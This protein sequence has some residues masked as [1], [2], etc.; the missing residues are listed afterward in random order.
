MIDYPNKL[1]KIFDKL[2]LFNIKPIIVGGYIRDILIKT[3]LNQEKKSINFTFSKDIDIEV[4]GVTSLNLLEELLKEFG[5]VNSVGKSF[6]ICKLSF[7][8]LDL[9]FSLPRLDSKTSSGHKGF[10][11][12]TPPDIDFSMASFRRDFT[13]NSIGYDVQEKKIL[14]P[15]N[16]IKDLKNKTLNAI[17]RDTF[18]EDPL[19]VLRAVGFAARFDFELSKNTF[20]LC[21]EMIKNGLLNELSKERI[22]D[23]IKKLL[24]KSD[25][26]SIG[27]KLLKDLDAL[28]YFY[29]LKS[30]SKENWN[31]TLFALDNMSKLKMSDNKTNIVLMLAITCYKLSEPLTISF[32]SSLTTDRNIIK[33]VLTLM[34][35]RLKTE[36]SNSDI[37]KLAQNVNLE[38][39]TTLYSALF[40]KNK[41]IYDD[42]KTR[43]KNLGVLNERLKP[44]IQGKELIKRGLAPSEEFS[45]IIALAYSAQMNEEFKNKEEATEWLNNTLLI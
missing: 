35:N 36:M 2:E 25:S 21:K 9:D 13:I 4:Y 40:K 19:R 11:I 29:E 24:L 33:K 41:K 6:G 37:Y 42:T 22:F 28:E 18:L 3:H 45:K 30:L 27:F 8:G 32:I 5:S 31:F 20:L 34:K 1:D 14:D 26:P 16:G 38:E 39:M 17:N 12:I 7:D 44:L 10:A 43:A 23:E 15:Y